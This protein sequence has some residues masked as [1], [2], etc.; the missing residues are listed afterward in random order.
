MTLFSNAKTRAGLFGFGLALAS[1]PLALA[2]VIEG[3]VTATIAEN[4]ETA[5]LEG[6]IVTIEETG[7]QAATERDGGFRFPN[8][9]PGDYTLIIDYFGAGTE[10][11]EVTVA[12]DAPAD[13]SITLAEGDMTLGPVVV[14]GQRGA[15][16]AARQKERAAD[17]LITVLS[18]DAIGSLPDENVAESLRRVAGVSIQLDQGEGRFVTVRGLDPSLNSTSVNGVRLPAPEGDSRAVALDVIDSDALES[19]TIAKS[20]T[21][22]MDGDGLGGAIDI[23]TTTAF[24]RGGRYLRAKALGIYSESSEAWGEKL[25]LGAS[26]IFMDG[27]LGVAGSITWNRRDFASE[28]QETDGPWL[29]DKREL[30]PE[31]YEMRDYQVERERLSAALNIDYRLG[32]NTDLYLRTLFNDFSDA[33]KRSRVE[34]T[35]E[36]AELLGIVDQPR[37]AGFTE[38]DEIEFDR[39]IKDREET[40]QIWSIQAGGETRVDSLTFDYQLAYSHSEEE[41]SDRLDTDFRADDVGD[42]TDD[43]LIGLQLV[44]PQRPRL[45]FLDPTTTAY[46]YDPDNFEFDEIANENGLT[47]DD[48]VSFAANLRRDTQFFGNSGFWK[49]G[50]KARLREKSRNVDVDIYDGFDSD[51]DLLLSPFATTV[52]YPLDINGPVPDAGSVRSFFKQNQDSFEL[53]AIDTALDSS[54]ADYDADENI[55][56]AYAMAQVTNGAGLA[57][58]GGVR[59]EGTDFTANGVSA[60]EE[61]GEFDDVSQIG[62]FQGSVLLAEDIDEEDGEFARVSI[63]NNFARDSYLDVLPSINV[64]YDSGES[65]VFR[66]SYYE[67]IARPDFEDIVPSSEL[68]IDEDGEI[69][70]DRVGNPDLERQKAQAFDISG[71]LYLDNDSYLSIGAFYKDLDNYIA[72]TRARDVTF[73]GVDF[74]EV[75]RAVNLESADVSGFELSYYNVF[76]SL[77]APFDGVL[78]GVNLTRTNGSAEIEGIGEIDLPRL[79]DT[80]ANAI[81]GYDKYGL[82]LRLAVNYRTEYLDEI[83]ISADRFDRYVDDRV[84]VDIQAQYDITD[85]LELQAELKNITDEPFEAYLTGPDGV[86]LLSQYEEY[87]YTALVGVRFRY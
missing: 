56:A 9:A 55:Y 5:P 10:T 17:S 14:T 74:D 70:S 22:D 18:S 75:V 36:D 62:P 67:S 42:V 68:E 49:I 31:Q 65:L 39:D 66:A 78:A 20:L 24:D 58:T 57:V 46:F 60:F 63:E 51:D 19:I 15:F 8:V 23:E 72:D 11:V 34:A 69:D 47:E 48:E 28:N 37:V 13:L 84:Q 61:E 71:A 59:L 81:I 41:E 29:S 38:G 26:D 43:A 16:Y 82:D 83:D 73:F 86:K 76:D 30:Y 12:E 87:G 85:Q 2:A 33:E 3:S 53:N 1:S 21:P 25:S 50:A 40:Q 32:G 64:R 52:D 45:V 79:S 35:F 44:N 27:A 80:V 77:P 4:G 54:A 6:A 7:A